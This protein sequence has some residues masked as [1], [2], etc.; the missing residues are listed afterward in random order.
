M[1]LHNRTGSFTA[2]PRHHCSKTNSSYS[3]HILHRTLLTSAAPGRKKNKRIQGEK[4]EKSPLICNRLCFL[5]SLPWLRDLLR[6]GARERHVQPFSPPAPPLC[7]EPPPQRW[8]VQTGGE[9]ALT[10]FALGV[11]YSIAGCQTQRQKRPQHN[12]T[13]S[14]CRCE[15]G[16]GSKHAPGVAKS[17]SAAKIFHPRRMVQQG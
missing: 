9:G 5:F 1:C 14:E 12:A 16:C 8:R 17:P 4:K 7:R 13:Q 3:L 6:A 11:S 2:E 15:S 10:G